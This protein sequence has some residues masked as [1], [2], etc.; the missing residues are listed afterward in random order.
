MYAQSTTL[1]SNW[2]NAHV[3]ATGPQFLLCDTYRFTGHHVGDINREYY[4]S[5]QEE[6][7]GKRNAIPITLFSKWLMEQKIWTQARLDQMQGGS[8][9]RD[10]EGGSVRHGGALPDVE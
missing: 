2:S 1:R 4:R 6:Q 8:R 5:K 7:P 3:L 10:E 9:V